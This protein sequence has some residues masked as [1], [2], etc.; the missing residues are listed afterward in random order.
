VLHAD[1]KAT[2]F[3]IDIRT[4]GRLEKF[5]YDMLDDENVSFVKGK[6]GKIGE[7]PDSGD[8]ALEVEDTVAGETLHEQFDLVVLATGMVPNTPD[9][10]LPFELI[11]DEYGFLYGGEDVDCLHVAGCVK[12]PCDVARSTRDATGAALKAI[13]GLAGGK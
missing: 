11:T 10:K 6:V 13:Q 5:Y 2:V 12:R 9:I 1:A 4:I 7:A 8:L 3:Y